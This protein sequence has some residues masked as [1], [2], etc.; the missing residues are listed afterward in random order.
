M[1]Y[2]RMPRIIAA[3]LFA[4]S[5]ATVCA[6]QNAFKELTPGTST[7]QDAERVLGR[8]ARTVGSTEV[9]YPGS[10]G[11][12]KVRILYQGD[13]ISRI[14]VDLDP[15][16]S[17][18]ALISALGLRERADRGAAGDGPTTEFFGDPAF[19]A[20]VSAGRDMASGVGRVHYY[21]PEEFSAITRIPLRPKPPAGN[22]SS[23]DCGYTLGAAIRAKWLETGG[24]QGTLHC[25]TMNEAEAG[26]SPQGTTGRYAKFSGP[27]EP[28]AIHWHRT[29]RHAGKAFATY[30]GIY[31][32]FSDLGGSTSWLG[33]P[34][35]DEYD[36]R[37]GDVQVGRRS[38]FEGGYIFWDART[39]KAEARRLIPH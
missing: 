21:S 8:P 5:L 27:N 13:V 1:T 11:I 25:P 10:P 18:T 35:S 28:A 33:F 36:V 14:D 39:G 2:M 30:G 37:E 22:A 29:G 34:T 26:R 24:Q 32:V 4:L 9:E 23:S 19:V 6:A 20:L 12:A 31:R 7:R 3:V 16:V 17:R 38:D 15:P